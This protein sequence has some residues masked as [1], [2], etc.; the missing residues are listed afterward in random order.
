MSNF[1]ITSKVVAISS[2]I[3]AILSV[4]IGAVTSVIKSEH[5][6]QLFPNWLIFLVLGVSLVLL[7]SLMACLTLS[8]KDSLVINQR[9]VILYSTIAGQVAILITALWYIF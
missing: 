9:K 2:A 4:I 8:I 7:G 6:H 5:P 3:T 1:L